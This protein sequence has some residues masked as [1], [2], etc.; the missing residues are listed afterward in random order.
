MKR[1]IGIALVM[2]LLALY[3]NGNVQV[4]SVN[5]SHSLY[6]SAALQRPPTLGGLPYGLKL[7]VN[8][9]DSRTSCALLL[10]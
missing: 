4:R 9:I 10:I 8:F 1:C 5:I 3:N 6:T 2:S 7:T